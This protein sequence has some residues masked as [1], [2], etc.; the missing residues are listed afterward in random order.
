MSTFS[1]L[2]DPIVTTMVLTTAQT[3]AFFENDDQ[4][5]IPH[6]MVIQLQQEGIDNVDDFADFDKNMLLQLADNL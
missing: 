2:S 3:T 4:M 5:G 6:A 1:S